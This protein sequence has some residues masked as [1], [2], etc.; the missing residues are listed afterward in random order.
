MDPI[1]NSKG[2]AVLDTAA[3]VRVL[4][5]ELKALRQGEKATASWEARVLS[6]V[7]TVPRDQIPDSKSVVEIRG[8]H[9]SRH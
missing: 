5:G 6:T 4:A 1:N 3:V 8:R 2:C 7:R 9:A